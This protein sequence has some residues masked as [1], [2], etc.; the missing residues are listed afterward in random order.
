MCRV[1]KLSKISSSGKVSD[2]YLSNALDFD[3]LRWGVCDFLIKFKSEIF[4]VKSI[5]KI[6]SNTTRKFGETFWSTYIFE[7]REETERHT[8]RCL[9]F[10]QADEFIRVYYLLTLLYEK[11]IKILFI[12]Y[13]NS[14]CLDLCFLI[15][16]LYGALQLKYSSNLLIDYLML[17][18][19]QRIIKAVVGSCWFEHSSW[20]LQGKLYSFDFFKGL[21]K[22]SN[23][24]IWFQNV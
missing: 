1:N 12:I 6:F 4:L 22:P 17:E 2:N 14:C 21:I 15:S 10:L 20:Y 24:I 7:L 23:Q 9:C 16:K 3:L 5:W 13:W 19:R 11:E 18:M 8:F